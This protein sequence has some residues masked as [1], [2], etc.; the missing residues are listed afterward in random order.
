IWA[1]NAL[2]G[3][4]IVTAWVDGPQTAE[5]PGRLTKWRTLLDRLRKPLPPAAVRP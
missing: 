4:R 5:E 3:I 2:H 1:V